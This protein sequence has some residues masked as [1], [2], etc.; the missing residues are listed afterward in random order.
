MQA[1]KDSTDNVHLQSFLLLNR[2]LVNKTELRMFPITVCWKTVFQVRHK[3]SEVTL[4]LW[5]SQE[6]IG[7]KNTA[8]A[9]LGVSTENSVTYITVEHSICKPRSSLLPDTKSVSAF[10]SNFPTPKSRN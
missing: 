1:D 7:L 6:N 10:I 9:F 5:L 4:W 2:E 8:S 3:L